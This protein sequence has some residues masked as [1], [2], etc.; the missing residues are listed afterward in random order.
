MWDFSWIMD[1]SA[2]AG[3]GTLVLLE[4]VLGVDNLVFISILVGRL[5]ANQKHRAFFTGLGL[6]LLMRLV[7]LAA[8]AWIIGLTAPLFSLG[9]HAFSARDLILMGGGVFLLFKGTL[10]LHERLE[11]DAAAPADAGRHAGFWRV[12]AQIIAL[13]AVF[14]LDSIITSVGMVE[15]VSIMMLAVATA[16]LVMG[17]AAAPLLDFVERHPSIIVLCL[18]FLLMIGLSLLT[19]GLGYHIPKG[20]LYAAIIFAVLVEAANQWAL[21]NRRKRISMRDMRESTARVVLGLLGGRSAHGEAQLDAAA[22]AGEEGHA[23]FAPEERAMVAR[24]IRLSGRTARFIM[25]PRQRV[26]WLDSRADRETVYRFA[27]ASSLPWLPVLRRETDEV[28]GVARTG[29][30]L[31]VPPSSA[32]SSDGRWN[33][34]EY[35]RPAPTIFEHTSLADILDD[36]RGHPAPLSFVRDEYGS[37]VGLITPAELLSVLAGQ[38]GDM[39]AGPESCRQPDGSWRLPGRLSV[40]AVAAWLGVSLPPRSTSATLAGLILERLGHIPAVGERLLLQG[41]ELEITS[42][43]RQRIDGVRAVRAAPAGPVGKPRRG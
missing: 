14:S 13:D 40:D 36:Y 27:A 43:D 1:F 5:P 16:M 26:N 25:I 38:V 39:P 6:A 29:E 28:L 37:V 4:V 23:L 7:L 42:M 17:L 2:W 32:A 22:L 30:L 41:W 21:R 18:G 34:T 19:E 15:H 20:Y 12:I 8:I 35:I 24:V 10:E 3:L 31:S 9:G 33:L 11:G